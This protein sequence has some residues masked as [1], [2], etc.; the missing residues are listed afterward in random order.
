MKEKYKKLL[1]FGQTLTFDELSEIQLSSIEMSSI[2][3]A[4]GAVTSTSSS[5]NSCGRDGA[6]IRT[7]PSFHPTDLPSY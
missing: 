7:D 1:N 3:G 6:V 4:Y 5:V 2:A